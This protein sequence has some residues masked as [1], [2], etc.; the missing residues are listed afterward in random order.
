MEYHQD[1]LFKSQLFL[2]LVIGGIIA[3]PILSGI[4][5]N[6]I[7]RKKRKKKSIEAV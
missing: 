3:I 1:L 2:G 6:V 4:G 5:I 7:I